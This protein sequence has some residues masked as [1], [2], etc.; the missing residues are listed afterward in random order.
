ML[1]SWDIYRDCEK[2]QSHIYLFNWNSGRFKHF[3]TFLVSKPSVIFSYWPPSSVLL[4]GFSQ[5]SSL[6]IQHSFFRKKS[7]MLT[8]QHFCSSQIQACASIEW[9]EDIWRGALRNL[10]VRLWSQLKKRN[11]F[12][13]LLVMTMMSEILNWLQKIEVNLSTS[14]SWEQWIVGTIKSSWL[15]TV[16]L[17]SMLL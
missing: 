14:A 3:R 15:G 1:G 11:S 2:S 12:F 9:E 7:L 8:P 13:Q 4:S 6:L 10:R 5:L 16:M 17:S